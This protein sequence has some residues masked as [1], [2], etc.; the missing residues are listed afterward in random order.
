MSGPAARVTALTGTGFSV[1]LTGVT[2]VPGTT[3]KLQTRALGSA[4]DWVTQSTGTTPAVGDVLSAAGLTTGASLEWRAIEEIGATLH[5]GTH[6]IVTPA[7]SPWDTLTAAISSALQG[8]GLP[9]GNIYIG[10]QPEPNYA[11][12]VAILRTLEERVTARANNVERIEFPVEVEFRVTVTDDDGDLQKRDSEKWQ[13][14]LRSAIHEKHAADLPG[15]VGL[16]EVR[17]EVVTKNERSEGTD[18]YQDHVR[19]RARVLFAI[20]VNK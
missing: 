6:G 20:W 17:V 2:G 18:Q 1:T 4:A 9:A 14:R 15:V 13:E 12:V 11:D 10:G 8:Q 16:E 5:D 3:A 19:V 7:E